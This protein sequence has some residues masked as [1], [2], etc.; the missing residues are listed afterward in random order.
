MKKSHPYKAYENTP[1]WKALKKGIADLVD[2]GDL[3]ELTSRDLVIGYLAKIIHEQRAPKL[4]NFMIKMEDLRRKQR[5][6]QQELEK[7]A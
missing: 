7:I 4:K 2:N 1:T 3:A 6:T 5:D